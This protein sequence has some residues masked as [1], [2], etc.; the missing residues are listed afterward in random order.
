MRQPVRLDWRQPFA[1]YAA[2]VAENGLATLAR[3]AAQKPVLAFP[4]DFRWLILSFHK[5]LKLA[6]LSVRVQGTILP[7]KDPK[8]KRGRVSAK[9]HVSTEHGYYFLPIRR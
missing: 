8:S 6:D 7:G 9:T 5:L 4:P 1:A 3:I 2:A